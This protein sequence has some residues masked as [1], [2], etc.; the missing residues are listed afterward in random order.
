LH[1]LQDKRTFSLEEA[2]E[3]SSDKPATRH[4]AKQKVKI[5]EKENNHE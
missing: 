1:E 3:L 2:Y 5:T 4:D